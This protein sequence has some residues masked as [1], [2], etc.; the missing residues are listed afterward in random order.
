VQLFPVIRTL[1]P[2]GVITTKDLANGILR[3]A[4]AGASGTVPGWEGKGRVGDAGVFDNNEIK[5][6]AREAGEA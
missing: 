5:Q 2:A 3:V 6:L 1:Y 4:H